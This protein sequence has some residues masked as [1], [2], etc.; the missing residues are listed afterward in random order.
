MSENEE[1]RG[2]LDT[3]GDWVEKG[4]QALGI[5]GAIITFIKILTGG[6]K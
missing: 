1:K 4:G 5:V 3:A 6:K 2:K